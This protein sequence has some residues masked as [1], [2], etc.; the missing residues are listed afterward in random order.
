[1]KTIGYIVSGL[2]ILALLIGVGFGSG[3]LQAVYNRTVGVNVSSSQ[4]EMFHHGKAYTEGMAQDLARQKEE[5]DQTT[6]L[7]ARAAIINYIQTDFADYDPATIQNPQL[8]QFLIDTM[9]GGTK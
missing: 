6:D 4:T 5:L 3:Y 1:M 2:V 7:T 9:N 8:R